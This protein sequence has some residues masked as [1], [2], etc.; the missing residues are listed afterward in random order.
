AEDGIRADLVT[1]VQTCALPIY[2]E[3][4]RPHR[5]DTLRSTA[6]FLSARCSA[7]RAFVSVPAVASR[8]RRAASG[9]AAV[10][11]QPRPSS[12][13]RRG[14]CLARGPRAAARPPGPVALSM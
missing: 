12:P 14:P 11:R 13:I 7:E 4:E 6:S 10:A 1:G 8:R 9:S 2:T 3:T 5:Q